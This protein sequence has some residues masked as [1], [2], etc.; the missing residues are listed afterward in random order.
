VPGDHDV[1][2]MLGRVHH[3][4]LTSKDAKLIDTGAVVFLR[5]YGQEIA[6]SG[7]DN[8]DEPRVVRQGF[9]MGRNEEIVSALFNNGL[10]RIKAGP[11][12]DSI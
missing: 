10:G 6:M 1:A 9:R 12:H 3:D 8:L 5:P 7:Q 2:D 4:D 11:A